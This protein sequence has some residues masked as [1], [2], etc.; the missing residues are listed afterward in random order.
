VGFRLPAG[1]S[2]LRVHREFAA[3]GSSNVRTGAYCAMILD[4]VHRELQLMF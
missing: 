4:G 2:V 3:S 1:L